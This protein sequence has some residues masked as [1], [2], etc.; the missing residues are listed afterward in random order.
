MRPPKRVLKQTVPA[1][2]DPTLPTL[3]I[4][5]VLI[6]SFFCLL[7]ASAS[8]VFYFKSNAPSFSSYF[9]I[10]ATYPLGHFMAHE[11]VI[12][13]HTRVLGVD[14]NPGPFSVKEAILIRCVRLRI[15]LTDVTINV[16]V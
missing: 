2:D 14:L 3:T 12:R 13:R 11:R 4:R 1:T 7:G 8:Q 6:G 15:S 10:L 16:I 5:V 9:V